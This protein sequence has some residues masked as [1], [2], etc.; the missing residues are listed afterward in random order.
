MGA[1]FDDS[2]SRSSCD[3]DDPEAALHPDGDDNGNVAPLF[4]LR[5]LPQGGQDADSA[6]L[7]GEGHALSVYVMMH[8]YAELRPGRE[9]QADGRAGYGVSSWQPSVRVPGKTTRRLGI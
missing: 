7:P 4:R 5:R 9:Q 1:D 2:S 8:R 3:D 6:L